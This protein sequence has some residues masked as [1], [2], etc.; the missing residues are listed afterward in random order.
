MDG[1]HPGRIRSFRLVLARISVF[2]PS[3]PPF[4]LSRMAAS[5]CVARSERVARRYKKERSREHA[6]NLIQSGG[7]TEIGLA[8]C[9]QPPLRYITRTVS[10]YGLEVTLDVSPIVLCQHRSRSNASRILPSVTV[11]K[12]HPHPSRLIG[13]SPSDVRDGERFTFRGSIFR[14]RII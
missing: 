5:V 4:L 1:G 14:T 3:F 2:V 11:L 6:G 9:A 12:L 13:L 10:D 7:K 8:P